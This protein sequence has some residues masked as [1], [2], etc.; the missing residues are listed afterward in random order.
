MKS[1]PDQ[2][3]ET[4]ASESR[5]THVGGTCA[6]RHPWSRCSGTSLC[7]AEV[8]P[9]KVREDPD[10]SFLNGGLM[11]RRFPR[12]VKERLLQLSLTF[13]EQRLIRRPPFRTNPFRKPPIRILPQKLGSARVEPPPADFFS[14]PRSVGS[15]GRRGGPRFR[16]HGSHVGRNHVGGFYAR[17][18]RG[19]VGAR[20]SAARARWRFQFV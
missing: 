13:L 19:N 18:L 9:I 15:G 1:G 5:T 8:H 3:Q 14:D 11:I 2:Q 20:A 4:R 12:N 17:G 10:G 7:L 6:I 16:G